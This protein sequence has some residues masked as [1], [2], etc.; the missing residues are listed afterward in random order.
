MFM[1]LNQ[2]LQGDYTVSSLYHQ[3]KLPLDIEISIPSD[4]PVRLVSAF[5]EEMNLSDL[6]ETYDRIRKSQASP[7]QMLKIVIYAAMNRIYSSRDIES[8]C[9]RD[10]NFMYL[11]EGAPAP[12]HSTLARFISLHL[13]QCSKSVMSQVGTILLD[14]GEISGENIFIDGTKIESV[15]NKYTF[16][17]KKAVTKNMAKLAEKI[18]MFCA[19]CEELYDFKV[20]YKDQISLRTLKRLR[21][22]LYKIKKDE[23]IEFVHGIGKRKTMLQRSIEKLEE[24]TEKLK[25]YTNKLYKCGRRNS[26]SKTD[27][28]ATFMR[29]KEDAMLNGQLKPAYNL[30]HGV[31]AEYVTWLGIY[32]NPTDTLT[33]IPFL[34]DMEEH[35]PF[36]YKNI[37]ADAGYESEENY[38]FIENND[39]TG[40]IKPQNYELSKTRKFKKDISKRENMDYDSETD[41]YT[42]KNGKKLL[43]VSKRK[44]KT[45]TDYQ[46]EVTIYECESCHECPFKKDC[47]KGNNCKTPFEDRKKVLSVSRKM[48]EKRAEC[49]ERITSDYGTQLRMN[50][51][52]QAEGSFAN[53]KED[54]NFRRY[55]YKGS[56]NVL[57]QSTLLAIAFDINKL[58]HKIMSE[59][60]GT[61]LFELKKVS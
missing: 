24:Y 13:S 42:C 35:L 56:E 22:K 43:A 50:R 57:A 10:I 23:A 3:I 39:Q 12:D 16:V 44:Q 6:Y 14:L 61:H 38:V 29:M 20:V 52:I 58:H 36:K 26:Y 48:E 32:P 34:K 54:M 2:I 33:L 1:R 25:E 17:W 19:E 40:Y 8:S 45:A 7:R 27:N 37:V 18:C 5:V 41:S 60:T 11:L 30:Q 31:D 46:R 9:K 59:R 15:A 53:V 28:D 49:L 21:K 51:S 4:D 55:L 47:I